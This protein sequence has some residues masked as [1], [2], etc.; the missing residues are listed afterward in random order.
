V[1]IVLSATF[2]HMALRAR[3]KEMMITWRI[4]ANTPPP[5]GERVLCETIGGK[6]IIATRMSTDIDGEHFISDDQKETKIYKWADLPTGD[7]HDEQ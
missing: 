2:N 6:I 4:V 7:G 3:E 1:K 5:Y